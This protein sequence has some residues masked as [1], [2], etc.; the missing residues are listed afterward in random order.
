MVEDTEIDFRSY[1]AAVEDLIVDAEQFIMEKV[2]LGVSPEEAGFTL[3]YDTR[4]VDNYSDM[5]PKY[6]FISDKRN[7]FWQLDKSLATRFITAPGAAHLWDSAQRTTAINELPWRKSE[8]DRWISDCDCAT[9]SLAVCVQNIGGATGRGTEITSLNAENMGFRI[10]S[11]FFRNPGTLVFVLS[12]NKTTSNTGLDRIIAHAVPFRLGRLIIMMHA[13]VYP[14]VGQFLRKWATSGE[15]RQTTQRT[16]VFPLR[17]KQ[18]TSDQ[19]GTAMQRAFEDKLSVGFRLRTHRHLTI[20]LQRH[21]LPGVFAAFR[22]A[23]AILDAQAGHN[24]ETAASNYAILVEEFHHLD[25]STVLKYIAASMMWWVKTSPRI[26]LPQEVAEAQKALPLINSDSTPDTSLKPGLVLAAG[27]TLTDVVRELVKAADP[28]ALTTELANQLVGAIG[29][30]LGLSSLSP[31]RS[32]GSPPAHLVQPHAMPSD[33]DSDTHSL[34]SAGTSASSLRD[35]AV[36]RDSSDASAPVRSSS[37]KSAG[38]G[39]VPSPFADALLPAI[40]HLASRLALVGPQPSSSDPTTA[41]QDPFPYAEVRHVPPIPEA[42]HLELL[43]RYTGD[44]KAVWTLP[45]QAKALTS[46]LSR[47][48]SLLVVLPTGSGKTVLF[49]S[50]PVIEFGTTVVI[51]PLHAL[52]VDQ[53]QA[54]AA[55]GIPMIPWTVG[56]S[57]PDPSVVAVSVERAGTDHRFKDWCIRLK[58]AGRLNRIV[59]DEAHLLCTSRSF[60]QVMDRMSGFVRI[61]V[62]LVALTGTL[63]PS[64]EPLLN[65]QL[66]QPSWSVVREPTQRANI[67][68]RTAKYACEEHALAALK[69]HVRRFEAQLQPGEGLLVMCRTHDD[70]RKVSELLNCPGYTS[71]PEDEAVRDKSATDW[72]AG[73]VPTIAATSALGTGVNHPRCRAVFH[74]NVPYGMVGYGQEVGRVGRDGFLAFAF[75]IHWHPPPGPPEFDEEGWHPLMQM[76]YD[77]RCIRSHMS[78]YLDGRALQNSCAG[79]GYEPCDRCTQAMERAAQRPGRHLHG[80]DD[81]DIGIPLFSPQD[82]IERDIRR[83]RPLTDISRFPTQPGSIPAGTQTLGA[84]NGEYC[85]SH[86]TPRRSSHAFLLFHSGIQLATRPLP[87]SPGPMDT[88]DDPDVDVEI[89]PL[90]PSRSSPPLPSL[91]GPSEPHGQQPGLVA[92]APRPSVPS[93]SSTSAPN[94]APIPLVLELPNPIG[95]TILADVESSRAR[96]DAAIHSEQEAELQHEPYTFRRLLQVKRFLLEDRCIYCALHGSSMLR[97]TFEQCTSAPSTHYLLRGY[98][99]PVG[100]SFTTARAGVRSNALAGHLCWFCYWPLSHDHPSSL[101]NNKDGGCIGKDIVL[102]LCWL[103]YCDPGYRQLLSEHFPNS[104]WPNGHKYLQW[105]AKTSRRTTWMGVPASLI[106]AHRVLIYLIFEVRNLPLSD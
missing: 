94:K 71:H 91:A 59:I 48:R 66:G 97:H 92:N 81:S 19:L 7:P 70:V 104:G 41:P 105:L 79:T 34:P 49:A 75:L 84:A 60:R 29:G 89:A 32:T 23:I 15:A 50:L 11:M 2:L 56:L 68:L 102:Q 26:L 61:G 99:G 100:C 24:S 64:M 8:V 106:N 6:S 103:A 58:A 35:S 40:N 47:L 10:R 95:P 96:H 83:P 86:P 17:G 65:R 72:L 16:S 46:V 12:Y 98:N 27:T 33:V 57:P 38:Q 42:K 45:A 37:P 43:R 90:A 25:H 5:S 20:A 85:S 9:K 13:L 53:L 63:P 54:A 36:N 44:E 4:I 74:F 101:A 21:L 67:A 69:M 3:Q 55:K 76:L 30:F 87:A 39:E 18:M 52:M 78:L 22:K 77:P 28:K 51:F 1:F 82:W 80:P 73:R 31:Q 93:R 62:P 88:D 14:L